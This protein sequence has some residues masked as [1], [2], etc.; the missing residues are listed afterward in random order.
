MV[1]YFAVGLVL[2]A[3][4]T[5]ATVADARGRGGCSGGSCGTNYYAPA[6][7]YGGCPGGAC[8][9]APV[10]SRPVYAAPVYQQ[11]PV[12]SAPAKAAVQPTAPAVVSAPFARPAV[13]PAQL[14]AVRYYYYYTTAPRSGWRQ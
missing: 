4:L 13:A 9:V 2:A 14:P 11:A 12:Y 8:G 3:S 1:K 5:L 10:Y 7:S 6:Y